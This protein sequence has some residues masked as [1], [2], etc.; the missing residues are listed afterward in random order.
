MYTTRLTEERLRTWAISQDDRERMCLG[1]LALDV[2][3]SNVKPRRPKGGP[4]GGR[5]I[6]ALFDNRVV[7]WGAVGFR[8]NAIDSKE[9]KRWVEA[10]FK[11][12]IEVA[13]TANPDLWGF[14]FFTNVDLTPTELVKLEQY[15]R[16]MGLSFVE[17]LHRERLRIA[18]DS[19]R[20]LSLRYQH[21]SISLSEAEQAAFFA[22]YGSQ[23][24]TLLHKGFGAI[25]ERLKRM[26]FFHDCSKPLLGGSVILTLKQDSTPEQLGHFR[27]MAEIMNMYEPDPHPALWIA[28][29]D[30]YAMWHSGGDSRSLIGIRSIAWSRN[31]DEQIQNTILGGASLATARLDAW[32]HLHKRGPYRTLGDLDRQH[33][34]IYVTKPLLEFVSS[35]YVVA[36]DYVLAGADSKFFVPLDMGTLVPWPEPLTEAEASVPWV[37][38]MRKIPNPPSWMIPELARTG[39]DV[40]FSHYTPQKVMSE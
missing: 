21:L 27:F 2:R 15:A 14:V 16:A 9:D 7:V 22:E 17:I 32:A 39:W 4:D 26:E 19:P 3:F 35:I 6:E 38:V 5:D 30:A 23:I 20:G 1:I 13:K 34:S 18:L 12:D 10:K 31:P 40:N 36:N 37:T 8:A 25:D 11:T 24:E 28:C 33:L 29:R